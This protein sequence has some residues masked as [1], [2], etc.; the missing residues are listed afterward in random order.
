MALDLSKHSILV[1][2]DV[3]EMRTSLRALAKSMG[4]ESVF[5]AKSGA[6][7]IELLQANDIT[8]VLCDY[9]LG[10]GRD[11][12]QVFEEAKEHG[13]IA[14]TTAFVMITADNTMDVVMAV[15]EHQPDG[16]LIKPLNKSVLEMR[17][18]KILLRK[19]VFKDIDATMRA[20][21]FTKAA[22]ICDIMLEN[23]PK[24]RFDLLRLKAE[25]LLAAGE[26]ERVEAL[27]DSI[28]IEREVPWATVYLARAR[29]QAG[30][31]D[32][33]HAL[34]T[35][36]VDHQDAPMEAFDWLTRIDREAGDLHAAQRTLEHAVKRSPKSIGRQQVLADVATDNGD[37]VTARKA[38]QAAVDL[39]EYSVYA[40]TE[41][42]VGLVNSVAETDGPEEALK[43]LDEINHARRPHGGNNASPGWRID[44]TYGQML[45]ANEEAAKAKASIAKALNAYSQEQRDSADPA[46][47]ALAKCCYRVGM[48]PEAKE[49]MNQIVKENHDRADIIKAVRQMYVEL[50]MEDLGEDLIDSARRAVV[51]INNRGVSLAK[52]GKLDEAITMLTKASDELPGNLTISLNVLQA[53][54]SQIR[55]AGFTTERQ[56][57][58]E[59]YVTRAERINADHPK[60][61]KL[62]EKIAQLQQEHAHEMRA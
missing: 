17:L 37:F 31:V 60:L 43:V 58:V 16:Y 24:L 42:E 35:E 1:V 48:I 39:G 34:L 6:E 9:Y 46:G 25:A 54:L 49:L 38:F 45:L 23:H 21:D 57:L 59:Q 18:E 61:V 5:L 13:M 33:A 20:G 26:N 10:E 52:E 50:G 12:Q 41:D 11:G 53:T 30:K 14:P 32:S 4:A 27:C 2:D 56:Y 19:R 36:L 15:V 47:L 28:L 3:R 7:A 51:E 55:F 29:Y 8:I 62:R 40:R 22:A 44:L